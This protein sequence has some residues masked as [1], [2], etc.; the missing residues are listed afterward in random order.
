MATRY[1]GKSKVTQLRNERKYIEGRPKNIHA[2]PT[3]CQLLFVVC[4]KRP[5]PVKPCYGRFLPVQ[6]LLKTVFLLLQATYGL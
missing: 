6:Q 5:Q 1:A 4:S 2:R 3:S